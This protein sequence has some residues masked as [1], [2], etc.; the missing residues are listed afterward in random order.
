MLFPRKKYNFFFSDNYHIR[1]HYHL[2]ICRRDGYSL[3][4]FKNIQN[5]L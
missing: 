5:H 2:Y 3:W 1:E 4:K